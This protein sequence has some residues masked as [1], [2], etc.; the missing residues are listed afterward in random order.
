M[1]G[2]PSGQDTKTKTNM[3]IVASQCTMEMGEYS[4]G[5]HGRITKNIKGLHGQATYTVDNCAMLYM[6]EI[7][8]L[9]GIPVSIVSDRDPR[10]T[11]AFGADSRNRWALAWISVQ[12]FIDKQTDIKN[13]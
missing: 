1:F 12:R 11:S 6:N 3:I 4:H 5:F 10:F 8:R 7:V 9:H 2:L 13:V